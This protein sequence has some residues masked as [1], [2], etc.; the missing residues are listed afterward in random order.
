MSVLGIPPYV[1][2]NKKYKTLDGLHRAILRAGA[3]SV[4]PIKNGIL[5][6]EWE[7]GSFGNYR[8]EHFA[9]RIVVHHLHYDLDGKM[10]PQGLSE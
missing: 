2:G 3:R 6:V 5:D 9:D 7:K 4:G 8:V 10:I 1:T